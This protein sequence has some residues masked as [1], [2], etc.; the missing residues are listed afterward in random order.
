[1]S[2]NH[3]KTATLLFKDF[4]WNIRFNDKTVISLL[5]MESIFQSIR[6]DAVFQPVA[7]DIR[8]IDGIDY[9]ALEFVAQTTYNGLCHPMALLVEHGFIGEKYA[10]LI[11]QLTENSPLYRIFNSSEAAEKW[12]QNF[13]TTA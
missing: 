12:L 11:E 13:V 3:P 7:L 4:Y 10:R 6:S 8:H 1:M 2:I 9:D 5:D